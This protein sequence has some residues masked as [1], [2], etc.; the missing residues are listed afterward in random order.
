MRER[1]VRSPSV[2]EERLALPAGCLAM[3]RVVVTGIGVVAP[4]GRTTPE[5]WASCCA[6]RSGIGRIQSFPI[7]GFPTKIAG[8]IHDYN[9]APLLRD[10]RLLKLL[11]R[12]IRFAIG[13]AHEAR[14]EAGLDDAE[15]DPSRFGVCMG[16]GVIPMDFAELGPIIAQSLDEQGQFDPARFGATA[17]DALFPLWLLKHLPNMLSAHLAILHHAEGPSNTL[18]RRVRPARKRWVKR[19]S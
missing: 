18:R 7:D 5:F 2:R 15:L 3:R 14:Q 1:N 8:E 12:H 6:G 9:V 10:R 13:A 17:P 11:G 4:N 19:F 16:S